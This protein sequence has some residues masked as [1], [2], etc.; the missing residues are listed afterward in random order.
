MIH[1]FIGYGNFAKAI[2]K[3]LKV[4]KTNK[5]FYNKNSKVNASGIIVKSE[6]VWLC[7]KPKDVANIFNEKINWGDKI[8]VSPVAGL[9]TKKL[10]ALTGNECQIVRVMTNLDISKQKVPLAYYSEKSKSKNYTK[11]LQSLKEISSLIKI[12][13]SDFDNFTSLFGSGPAFI[14]KI[15]QSI[16]ELNS[17]FQTKVE[18]RLIFQLINQTIA[19]YPNNVGKRLDEIASKGGTTEAG[20]KYFSKIKLDKAIKSVFL[21]ASKRSSELSR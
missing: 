9:T 7:V 3:A 4:D 14:I 1:G 21:E 12:K 15:L 8:V 5:F 6:V 17:V 2:H 19:N 18:R 13:E 16:L 20:L 10:K 11:L